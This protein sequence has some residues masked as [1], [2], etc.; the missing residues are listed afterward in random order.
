MVVVVVAIFRSG[1]SGWAC[2]GLKHM[3]NCGSMVRYASQ[4]QESVINSAGIVPQ[5]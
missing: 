2:G 1:P 4:I 5:I 3:M